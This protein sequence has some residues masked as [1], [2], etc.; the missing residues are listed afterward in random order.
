MEDLIEKGELI[1]VKPVL[2]EIERQDDELHAWAKLQPNFFPDPTV[3]EQEFVSEL[4]DQYF[5]PNKP[6]KGIDNADPFVI[7]K[8]YLSNPGM[9]LVHGEKPGSVENPKI[10]YVCNQLNIEE[11]NFLGFIQENGWEF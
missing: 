2:W 8:S 4:M 10:P 7:S 3:E 9:V 11:R 5:N 1:S 6:D